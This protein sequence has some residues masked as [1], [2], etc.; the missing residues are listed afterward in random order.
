MQN[1][2]NLYLACK[3]QQLYG[4]VNYRD[5][6]ETGPW[7][8]T[9]LDGQSILGRY[10]MYGN[11]DTNAIQKWFTAPKPNNQGEKRFLS[12]WYIHIRMT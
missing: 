12:A 7:R 3:Q 6:R 8:D 11:I 2:W 1:Y 9:G 10:V 5:F 4:P